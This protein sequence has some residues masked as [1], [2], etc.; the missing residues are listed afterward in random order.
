MK[1]SF[2]APFSAQII[3]VSGVTT[4]HQGTCLMLAKVI[5]NGHKTAMVLPEWGESHQ[6]T[7]MKA[8]ILPLCY[9]VCDGS[10]H[11]KVTHN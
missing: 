1:F 8:C 6:P 11:L 9:A 10:P 7:H 3:I 4:N 5:S 2:T